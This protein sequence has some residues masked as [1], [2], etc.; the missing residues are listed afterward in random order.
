MQVRAEILTER[1]DDLVQSW[2]IRPGPDE[3][4]A[5]RRREAEELSRFLE[6]S[7]EDLRSAQTAL[8][9]L[10]ASASAAQCAERH[11]VDEEVSAQRPLPQPEAL[12]ERHLRAELRRPSAAA[13]HHEAAAAARAVRA[14]AGAARVEAQRR[15]CAEAQESCRRLRTKPWRKS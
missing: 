11:A 9:R 3:P 15:R 10:L 8:E 2:S 6:Q 12:P 1:A 5:A 4:L 14:A 7:L 13:S